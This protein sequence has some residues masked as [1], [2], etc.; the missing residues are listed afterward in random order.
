MA[1]NLLIVGTADREKVDANYRYK[2]P[3]IVGK[4]EGRGNGK[5]TA[6]PNCD[7]LAR[8]LHRTP[9]MFCKFFGNELGA[10]ST[11]D[12][13]TDRALVNGHINDDVLQDLTYKFIDIFVLCPE[14]HLPETKLKI[15][16]SK[17]NPDIYHKCHACGAKAMVDMGHKLCAFIIAE[18]KK[19]KG[20]KKKDKD[21]DK[22]KKKK[23]KK[24]KVCF[25]RIFFIFV[26][27]NGRVALS[28]LPRI[29]HTHQVPRRFRESVSR[30]PG[31][32]V[33][34]FEEGAA[35]RVDCKARC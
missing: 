25:R 35:I 16:G 1:D 20:E 18:D 28:E 5:K 4:K 34:G 7:R 19:T 6:I 2:M 32:T 29:M 24:E 31:S 12:P 11:W 27:V 30:G 21:K 10:V 13:E 8:V 33:H 9:G 26:A 17:K 22:D 23:K 15:E 3:P 14:C